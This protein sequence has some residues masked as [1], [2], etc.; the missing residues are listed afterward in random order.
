MPT[1]VLQ[2]SV[3]LADRV[4][5]RGQMVVEGGCIQEIV[6]EGPRHQP[7][8]DYG[9]A[10]IL[11]GLIDLHVHGI[12][13][14]DVMD[15]SRE[16]LALMARRFATHGVTGF[17]PTTL[18]QSLD[19]TRRAMVSIRDSMDAPGDGGARVLGIH[20]EG[21]FVN[22]A[23][24]GMQNEA[25][26]QPPDEDTARDLIAQ[27]PGRV[28]RVSLAPELPGA[29]RVI[30]LLRLEGIYVS[31]A[32]TGAT[33]EQVLDAIDLGATQVTHCFNAMTGLHHRRPGVAGAAMLRDELYAELI[34]DGVHVH[35]A[36]MRLLIRLKGRERVMLVTDSMS[37][38]DMP[39]GR[40]TFGGHDVAVR[41]GV[42]RLGDGTLASSTLTMDAAV[43]NLVHLWQTPLVDAVYMGST[44]PADAIGLGA[45][46]GKLVA[47]YDA[48]LAV[49]DR[50][51][52]PV[53]TW[54]E[55]RQCWRRAGALEPS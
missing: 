18:T 42:A 45:R 51:L 46:K 25:Y 20:L 53:A 50:A 28:S 17:L 14:A 8:D 52:Q 19:L 41:G 55:G 33:Y 23:F 44:T 24:K 30:R 49:L 43:R 15:C 31:I 12:A 1:H 22:R 47:G 34:A 40:Y 26:I 35:P 2:G 39:D 38:A 10:Y 4:V 5:R 3:V 21:P 7:T 11:P 27:A 48:D 54:V 32:H 9:E 6:T 37:A 29:D 36:V 16:A 13:G